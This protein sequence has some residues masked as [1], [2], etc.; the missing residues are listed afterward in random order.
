MTMKSCNIKLKFSLP[1]DNTQKIRKTEK[2]NYE[3]PRQT[4]LTILL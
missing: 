2:T 1:R 4:L 3:L